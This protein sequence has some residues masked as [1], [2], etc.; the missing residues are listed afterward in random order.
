MLKA[1]FKMI[2]F[3]GATEDFLLLEVCEMANIWSPA[4]L[5]HESKDFV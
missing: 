5:F 4:V 2:V 3:H 1:V